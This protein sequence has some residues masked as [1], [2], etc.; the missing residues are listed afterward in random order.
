MFVDLNE[1]PLD[2]NGA[3]KVLVPMERTGSLTVTVLK[4]DGS[5]LADATVSTNPN[6]YIWQGGST[7][8]GAN[9]NAIETTKQQIAGNDAQVRLAPRDDK[10][11]VYSAVTDEDGKARLSGIPCQRN[12]FVGAHHDQYIMP[13]GDRGRRKPQPYMTKKLLQ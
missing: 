4:P 13:A 2:E 12:N 7:I 3:V 9:R 5:P 8:L 10:I 1:M 6:E 11:P